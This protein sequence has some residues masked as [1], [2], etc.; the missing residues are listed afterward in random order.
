MATFFSQLQLGASALM[1]H[2]SGISAAGH[3][4]ANADVEGHT[5]VNP[6]L[7]SRAI[8]HGGGVNVSPLTGSPDQILA[9]RERIADAAFGRADDLTS[10][11]S[12]LEGE[13]SL[14]QGGLVNAI[15]NLFGGILDLS[16]DPSDSAL[17]ASLVS[18]TR[19]LAAAFHRASEAAAATREA[20]DGR[21][22]SYAKAANNLARK[23]SSLN[24]Q[25]NVKEDPALADQRAQAARELTEL[26]GGKARVDPD[27]LM[28]FNLDDG[29]TLVDGVRSH[30]LSTAP[31]PGNGGHLRL[32]V[33][34][35][36]QS[37]DV[38]AAITSGRMGAQIEMRDNVAAT[39][40]N[41]V[42][43]LAFDLATSLNAVHRSHQGLDGSTGR[44][45][46]VQPTQVQGA[47]RTLEVAPDILADHRRIATGAVGAGPGDNAGV[48]A[49][50]ALQDANAAGGGTRTF[51]DEGVRSL[52]TLGVSVQ[53]AEQDLEISNVRR[54]SLAS[55]RDS[56]S[57]VSVEE[58]LSR[59]SQFQR[60]S[61][62]TTRFMSTVDGMLGYLIER[63]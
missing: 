32:L 45:F 12:T 50:A 6:N 42:D 61:E 39:L 27:G 26:V 7:D 29:T 44:D 9:Q 18:K 20:A 15:A 54:E 46:F 11:A 63:L 62:A 55:I 59:L 1:A 47:A 60:A 16:P 52:T 5:R 36:H 19:S 41:D 38:T 4:I 13:V 34:K 25:I 28:R 23:I 35:G 58:E 3:N 30:E 51:M 37:H 43:Q 48:Q 10:A 56:V 31:D 21:I 24:E 14:D 57:G 2:R 53:R 22:N 8:D 17:R 49:L 40:A 33:D